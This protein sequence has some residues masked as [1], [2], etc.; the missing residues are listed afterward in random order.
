MIIIFRTVCEIKQTHIISS[1]LLDDEAT[2][3][4]VGGIMITSAY[5]K[6]DN[7]KDPTVCYAHIAR[8]SSF[9]TDMSCNVM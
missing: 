9:D 7:E 8:K 1:A 2:L 3:N 4:F 6:Y 5:N